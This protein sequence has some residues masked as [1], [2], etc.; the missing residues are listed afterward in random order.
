MTRLLSPPN[1][2]MV[3]LRP[4]GIPAFISGTWSG[5]VDPIARWKVETGWWNQSVVRE[6]WKV[7]LN[8]EL[9]CELYHDLARDEWFVERIYD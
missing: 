1:E 9:L 4:G 6:Y 7:L 8:S 3:T 5:T 2:V